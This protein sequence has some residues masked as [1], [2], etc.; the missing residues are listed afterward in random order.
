VKRYTGWVIGILAWGS[1]VGTG[2]IMIH[3]FETTPGP[4]GDAPPLWPAG[5]PFQPDAGR[6]TLVMALHPHCPCSRASVR[7]LAA[8]VGRFPERAA[9]YVLVYEPE[10]VPAGWHENELERSVQ[11]I[12]GAQIIHDRDASL[13][14]QFGCETSGHVL[15][16][17]T[18][19]VLVFSG[20]IT[21]G[22]GQDGASAG[23]EVIA[24]WLLD[25]QAP[26]MKT[27][28]FGCPLMVSV[29]PRGRSTVP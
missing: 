10:E 29:T 25:R 11:K 7:E 16:Y 27:N 26:E 8:L 28:V 12:P 5:C 6:F 2:F 17:G 1:L 23:R 21:R 24:Q 18:D 22:R 13:A 20:G 14:H 4:R 3:R 15:L 19:G 9:V